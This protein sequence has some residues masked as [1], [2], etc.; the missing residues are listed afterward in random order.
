VTK[1]RR[2]ASPEHLSSSGRL[3]PVRPG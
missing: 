3:K 1:A 2:E